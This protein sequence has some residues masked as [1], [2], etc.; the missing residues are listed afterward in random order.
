MIGFR[1]D[2]GVY[3]IVVGTKPVHERHELVGVITSFAEVRQSF[4]D[5]DKWLMK[6]RRRFQGLDPSRGQLGLQRDHL[7]PGVPVKAK[8]LYEVFWTL[9]VPDRLP[10]GTESTS[11][12]DRRVYKSCCHEYVWVMLNRLF[13]MIAARVVPF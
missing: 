3:R 6:V 9:L 1:S 5:L 2:Q 8:Y 10:S 13:M 12:L 4:R 7:A 11:I